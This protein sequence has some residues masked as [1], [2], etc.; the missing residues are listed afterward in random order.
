MAEEI[1]PNRITAVLALSEHPSRRFVIIDRGYEWQVQL[2][3]PFHDYELDEIAVLAASCWSFKVWIGAHSAHF[4]RGQFCCLSPGCDPDALAFLLDHLGCRRA[5]DSEFG[6]EG[7]VYSSPPRGLARSVR[8]A[9]GVLVLGEETVTVVGDDV[10]H[11]V[12][13]AH[14]LSEHLAC[15]YGL[16]LLLGTDDEE[17]SRHGSLATTTNDDPG[18]EKSSAGCDARLKGRRHE[19]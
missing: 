15:S 8:A 2:D 6:F 16:E 7:P 14:P 9:G 1:I 11:A 17:E 12:A 19:P 5:P 13:E 10:V 4:S 3:P 18:V